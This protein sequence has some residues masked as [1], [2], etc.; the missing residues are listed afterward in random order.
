MSLLELLI[1]LKIPILLMFA[2]TNTDLISIKSVL[3]SVNISNISIFTIISP[4]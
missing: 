2:N 3:V 4:L 1:E